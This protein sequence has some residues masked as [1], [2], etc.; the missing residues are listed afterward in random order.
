M[1]IVIGTGWIE[2]EDESSCEVAGSSKTK[3]AALALAKTLAKSWIAEQLADYLMEGEAAPNYEIVESA[4]GF[5]V[6]QNL[7]GG[8]QQWHASYIVHEVPA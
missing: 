4:D 7:E 6:W 2:D 8:A 5:R 3:K 1:F